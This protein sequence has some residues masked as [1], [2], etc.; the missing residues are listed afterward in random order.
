[1]FTHTAH[2][3]RGL[4]SRVCRAV[5]AAWDALPGTEWLVLG[6]GSPHAARTY[7]KEGFCGLLGG[8]DKGK[9]GYNPDDQGEWIMLRRRG[10]A[11]VSAEDFRAEF[12]SVGAPAEQF[13][14]EP[15]S[16]AHWAGVVLLFTAF[17]PAA[18]EEGEGGKLALMGVDDGL[19][20]EERCC[21]LMNS[22]CGEEAAGASAHYQRA[23]VAIHGATGRVHG[24]RVWVAGGASGAY[25]VPSCK[26]ASIALEKQ[27]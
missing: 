6:T 3:Q 4:S 25:V 7:A 15:L 21:E 13:V 12:F 26:G 16:R 23:C 27:G 19:E 20:S 14:V 5:V 1:M 9:K 11:A 10:A 22:V 8:L 24:I 2:R 17:G 18:A